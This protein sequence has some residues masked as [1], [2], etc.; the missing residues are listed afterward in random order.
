MG[1]G[2]SELQLL[3]RDTGRFEG[4]IAPG[5]NP[6]DGRP[7]PTTDAA[8]M[9]AFTDGPDTPL[10][11]EHYL[12]SASR[13]R[14]PLANIKAVA[15]VEA[16]GAGFHA[17]KPKILPERHRFSKLTNS[18]F[19]RSHPH[20]SYQRWG[21]KP[22]PKTQEARYELLLQMIRLDISAG[23]AACS[24]GK[25]QI[26]GENHAACGYPDPHSFAFAQ[27]FDEIT[28]LRAFEKFIQANGLLTFLQHGIWTKFA[29]GYNGPAYRENR[30]DIKLAQAARKFE[31][32]PTLVA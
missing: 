29:R 28:Q 16:A 6:V 24:Y 25:F 13:M 26:L 19:D 4:L 11:H 31:L 12:E 14:C 18:R 9:R 2:W 3:L 27:A 17:G 22:Y 5:V 1:I 20:L 8:I 10:S 21:A 23:I 15:S 7:G 32:N 30:Y